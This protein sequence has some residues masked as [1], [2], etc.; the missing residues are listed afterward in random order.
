MIADAIYYT[1]GL[2]VSLILQSQKNNATV[3]A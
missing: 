3:V 1:A 2:L